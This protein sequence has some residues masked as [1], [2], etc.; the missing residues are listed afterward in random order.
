MKP[1]CSQMT[2]VAD[3]EPSAWV[4]KYQSA[5]V[6]NPFGPTG[7]V[8]L[9]RLVSTPVTVAVAAAA[10]VRVAPCG[11]VTSVRAASRERRV[12]RAVACSV[13]PTS[14]T[15]AASVTGAESSSCAAARFSSGRRVLGPRG[16]LLRP[17]GAQ[18]DQSVPGARCPRVGVTSRKLWPRTE[19]SPDPQPRYRCRLGLRGRLTRG[20]RLRR[21][22]PTGSPYRCHRR[23]PCPLQRRHCRRRARCRRP[24][25]RFPARTPNVSL[26][27]PECNQVSAAGKA[28]FGN[29][30]DP[31]FVRIA[32]DGGQKTRSQSI[33]ISAG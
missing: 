24:R 30:S 27:R 8:S 14:V 10:A 3:T 11:A 6:V 20:W 33:R 19:L 18:V 16:Q 1:C 28:I 26:T 7:M 25:L 23:T 21:A 32:H 9:A 22:A 12:S 15:S 31:L 29:V 17:G 13:P 5:R 4:G 2:P